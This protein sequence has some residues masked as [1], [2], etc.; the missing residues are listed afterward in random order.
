MSNR[1]F[2]LPA[3]VRAVRAMLH[4]AYWAGAT[5]RGNDRAEDTLLFRDAEAALLKAY[6]KALEDAVRGDDGK[7]H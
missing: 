3:L 2:W 1:E 7:V 4:T 5:S 6:G